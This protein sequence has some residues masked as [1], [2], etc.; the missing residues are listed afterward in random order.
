MVLAERLMAQ[1]EL[2]LAEVSALLG[3]SEQ[4]SFTRSHRRWF[5]ETPAAARRPMRSSKSKAERRRPS[6]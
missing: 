3:Y 4:S 5:G 2:S 6:R 1:R